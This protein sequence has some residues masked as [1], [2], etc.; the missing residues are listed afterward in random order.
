MKKISVE[1]DDFKPKP[2]TPTL[3]I[4]YLKKNKKAIPVSSLYGAIPMSDRTIRNVVATLIRKGILV[5]DK[6]C[7][8][9]S[10]R[11]VR[12]K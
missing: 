11:L 1:V 4:Q 9:G 8:C 10:T 5:D 2:D 6:K 3:I 12:L 7:E